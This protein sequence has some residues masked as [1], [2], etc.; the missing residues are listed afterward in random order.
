VASMTH[1]I[2]ARLAGGCALVLAIGLSGCAASQDVGV[3]DPA[4]RVHF[5]VPGG[6]R[7]IG[8]AALA[9]ELKTATPGS[10]TGWMVAYDAVPHSKAA[11]FLSFGIAQPFVFAEYGALNATTSR[12]L[13][14]QTLRDFFFPVT[15]AAR[16]NA[17]NEGFPLT[18]FRQLRDQVLTLGQGVHG[19]R[20]TYDYTDNG[21][22]DT[23]DMDALTD[24]GHTVVFLIVLHC[25]TA[26]YGKYQPNITHLMSSVTTTRLA[27]PTGPFSSLVGR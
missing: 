9:A 4:G 14:D 5:T 18:G 3:S 23:W 20:E 16:Q 15:S 12:E 11:D 7:Q 10:G 6:W 25:T 2:G 8:A 24:A 26:C 1:R 22:A 13:S 27:Q 19:V 21:Q 17:A